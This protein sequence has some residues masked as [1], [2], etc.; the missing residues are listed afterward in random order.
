M[1]D[2]LFL[3]RQCPCCGSAPPADAEIKAPEPAETMTLDALRPHWMGFFKDKTFFSYVRCS[4]CGL[5]YAPLFF[6]GPQLVDLYG[7]MP[8]NMDVV[9]I[10]ML[11]KTQRGYFD[12][13]KA[14]S[15]LKGGFLEI[16][17]DIGLFTENCV[18][19]G[20]FDHYWLFEPNRDVSQQ[21]AT[22]MGGARFDIV[23]D[24]FGFDCVPD[25]SIDAAVMVHVLDHLLDPVATLKELRQ[26]M[27]RGSRLLIVTH[28]EASLLRRAIGWRWPAFCLQHPELYNFQSIARVLDEAGFE[29]VTQQKTVNHFPVHFL[30]KHLLWA[31]GLKIE[32]LPRLGDIAVGLKLG[33]MLN[34]ATPRH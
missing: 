19:E 9:E 30:M 5:L 21:L 25:A 3:Q 24:M 31:T 29:I 8:P 16:G 34:I 17:P 7:Q 12:A 32:K 18:R 22:T 2:T 4:N 28:D 11:R 10:D 1:S 13:L 33:N 26:K 27:R 15:D 14:S 23:Y 20:A 6:T